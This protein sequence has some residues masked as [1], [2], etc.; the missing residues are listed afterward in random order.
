MNSKQRKTLTRVFENPVRAD[1]K[2]SDLEKLVVALGGK[3][4]EG[5]GSRVL[6]VLNGERG[7]FHR[8]HPQKETKRYAVRLFRNFLILAGVEHD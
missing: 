7:D 8:P 1:I 3:I 2:W 5:A 4:Y 6:L